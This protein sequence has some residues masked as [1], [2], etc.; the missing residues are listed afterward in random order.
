MRR[1]AWAHESSASITPLLL[2]K[3]CG[4]I[5]CVVEYGSSK[6]KTSGFGEQQEFEAAFEAALEGAA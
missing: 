5:T 1:V 6:A 3:R 2:L 4:E